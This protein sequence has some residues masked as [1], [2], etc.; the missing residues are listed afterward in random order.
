MTEKNYSL[1][2]NWRRIES[3]KTMFGFRDKMAQWKCQELAGNLPKAH[4]ISSDSGAVFP[5]AGRAGAV[6]A[7]GRRDARCAGGAAGRFGAPLGPL[8]LRQLWMPPCFWL[9]LS[10]SFICWGFWLWGSCWCASDCSLEGARGE[11]GSCSEWHQWCGCS[12]KCNSSALGHARDGW[13]L[14]VSAGWIQGCG[15][16]ANGLSLQLFSR[17]GLVLASME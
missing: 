6:R 10:R 14:F 16:T 13:K 1:F 4:I 11:W 7:A 15:S 9:M 12:L 3:E 8:D 2:K 5:D 17:T